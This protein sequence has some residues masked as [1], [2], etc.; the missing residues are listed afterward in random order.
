MREA[1]PLGQP[2]DSDA[3]KT[4]LKWLEEI[5]DGR[6][7]PSEPLP[8]RSSAIRAVVID[9]GGRLTGDGGFDY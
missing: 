8:P 2:H 6:T 7:L 1:K 5:R 3:H 4:R 9:L